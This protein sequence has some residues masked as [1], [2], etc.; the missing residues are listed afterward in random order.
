MIKYQAIVLDTWE[1]VN[2]YFEAGWEYVDSHIVEGKK[3]KVTFYFVL[4][5]GG[6]G[7][8]PVIIRRDRK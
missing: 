6:S 7:A 3:S 5:Q 8:V 2:S 1:A 4:R